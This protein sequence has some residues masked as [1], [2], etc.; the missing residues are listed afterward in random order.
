MPRTLCHINTYIK[1]QIHLGH[2]QNCYKFKTRLI[3]LYE[4]YITNRNS[5]FKNQNSS[6]LQLQDILI[7]HLYDKE[8]WWKNIKTLLDWNS[9]T[10]FLWDWRTPWDSSV[11]K[12][13][14]SWAWGLSS[15]PGTR[16]LGGEN[17]VVLW[18]PHVPPHTRAHTQR[19]WI[20]GSVQP[21]P[22]SPNT[23]NCESA[24][25]CPGVPWQFEHP[26]QGHT[27][28]SWEKALRGHLVSILLGFKFIFVFVF[29]NI[30]LLPDSHLPPHIQG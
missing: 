20:A 25:L 18:G 22:H 4:T 8:W 19:K 6:T 15:S 7:W 1:W 29:R 16:K 3:I 21:K 2:F 12:I 27:A 9:T 28:V 5:H 14:Y 17:Q 13:N 26:N 23:E 11:V 30:W 10:T 24:L